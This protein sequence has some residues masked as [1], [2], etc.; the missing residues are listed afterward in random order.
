MSKAHVS[1]SKKEL[2]KTVL[3]KLKNTP[4]VGVANLHGLP[5]AQLQK[6]RGLLREKVE[7]LMLKR[8]ITEIVFEN[9]SKEKQGLEKLNS[10]LGGNPALIF[11]RENPFSLYKIIKKNKSPAPAKAG[12]IAPKDI[13]VN[14]GPTPF[15]PGP[16]ISELK[17]L[18]INSGIEGGKIIIKQDAVVCKEGGV[19]SEALASML[20]RLSIQPMEIGLD[21]VAVYE[22]GIIYDKKVL[23]IDETVFMSNLTKA[24]AYAQNLSVEAAYPTKQNINIL[25][26]KAA[27][28]S[29]ALA[30]SQNILA[31]GMVGEVLGKVHAQMLSLKNQINFNGGE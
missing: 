23:D 4:I 13:I 21:I 17:Q 7:M 2:V 19:I 28:E 27:R 30:R 26:S 3:A 18:G 22:K 16:V 9:A 8:N 29:K 12:Q 24:I 20:L 14:A 10:Y 5:A 11:T 25:I 1:E 31:K 6:M 15:A